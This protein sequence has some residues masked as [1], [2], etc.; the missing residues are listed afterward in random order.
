MWTRQGSSTFTREIIVASANVIRGSAPAPD[1]H[2]PFVPR[3]QRPEPFA[4]TILGA[5][6]DLTS[7]KIIPALFGLWRGGFLPE[8]CVFVGVARREKSD[9]AFRAEMREALTRFRKDAVGAPLDQFLARLFY[10]RAE[11][12]RAED[13]RGLAER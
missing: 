12:S 2:S 9:D 13:M 5:T 4:L 10:H 7:R 1:T 11:F 8:E 6:G 3:T